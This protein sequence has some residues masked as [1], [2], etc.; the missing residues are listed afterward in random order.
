MRQVTSSNPDRMKFRERGG[1]RLLCGLPFLVLGL[2]AVSSP[3]WLGPREEGY[4]PWY[5]GVALG[6]AF[7]GLGA[8]MAL[9][10]RGLVLDRGRGTLTQ[11]WGL[12]VPLK[13]R[14]FSLA[15]HA[16]VVVRAEACREG[17]S[18]S[19]TLSTALGGP[20]GPALGLEALG[21]AGE[22]FQMARELAKFLALPLVD[23]ATGAE[24]AREDDLLVETFQ[25]WA[26]RT[27]AGRRAAALPV[28]R[29][30]AVLEAGDRVRL[31]LPPPGFLPGHYRD[32]GNAFW[33][34][35][36]AGGPLAIVLLKLSDGDWT[37]P[38]VSDRLVPCAFVLFWALLLSILFVV[39]SAEL[40]ETVTS[41]RSRTLVEASAGLLRV[42]RAGPMATEVTEIPAE[43]L[44]ELA[45]A[46]ADQ[47]RAPGLSAACFEQTP[48]LV[49]R[50]G[51]LRVAFGPGLSRQE[52]AWI[53]TLILNA[54]GRPVGSTPCPAPPPQR[55]AKGGV[56]ARSC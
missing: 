19:V 47:A 6:S 49:A 27:D 7:V 41:A 34:A 38:A 5:V 11:W 39:A 13:R 26:A 53:R 52:L 32:I 20:R 10:R 21:A 2:A 50:S 30:A 8:A 15:P 29:V 42:S 1:P 23:G 40:R 56:E 12:L 36:T 9:G 33:A 18:T 16:C 31:A 37:M 25:E 22:S 43:R 17:A 14:R 28:E 44:D 45:I 24:V 46:P 4:P 35:L 55:S 54:L 51:T 48:V 3:L